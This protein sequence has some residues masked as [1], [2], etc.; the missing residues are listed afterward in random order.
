MCL[1]LTNTVI[2]QNKEKGKLCKINEELIVGTWKLDTIY[3]KENVQ[4]GDYY[5]LYEKKFN[6]LRD[7]SFFVFNANYEYKKITKSEVSTGTWEISPDGTRITIKTDN[8]NT[9]DKSRILELNEKILMMNPLSE[10]SS[11]SKVILKRQE[12]Q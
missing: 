3:L 9:E 7:S 10:G 11:N 5:Y 8:N 4:F 1:L 12:N 6:E 2:A